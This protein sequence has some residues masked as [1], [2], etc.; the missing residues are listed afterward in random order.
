MVFRRDEDVHREVARRLGRQPSMQ[1][2]QKARARNRVGDVLQAESPEDQEETF[3]QLVAFLEDLEGMATAPRPPAREP[4]PP[5]PDA[6]AWAENEIRALEAAQLEDVAAFRRQVLRGR[7]VRPSRVH[8]WLKRQAR[9][10]ARATRTHGPGT[11]GVLTVFSS[12][13]GKGLAVTT[14]RGGVLDLLALLGPSLEE[15]FGWEPAHAMAWVLTGETAPSPMLRGEVRWEG[16]LRLGV[17]DRL[18]RETLAE[19]TLRIHPRVRPVDV[20][21]FYSQVRARCLEGEPARTRT[22]SPRRA[23]LAVFAAKVNDGRSWEAAFAEWRRHHP[24]DY[25]SGFADPLQTFAR[26]CRQAYQRVTGRPLAWKVPRG[27]PARRR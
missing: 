15:R 24:E 2:W 27:R 18:R 23:E 6:S 12:V 26:D 5:P 7:L 8:A 25:R 20:E 21:R 19:I 16:G 4:Q 14:I 1:A 11:F 3:G 17:G 10:D 22:V 9:A 13:E